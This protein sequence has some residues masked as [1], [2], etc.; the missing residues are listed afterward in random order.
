MSNSD[1]IFAGE[2]EID[3]QVRLRSSSSSKPHTARSRLG[4]SGQ[5]SQA[6]ER[7]D[8]EQPLL[9]A[10][11][12]SRGRAGSDG[13]SEL[14]EWFGTAELKGLPWWKKPSVCKRS[15]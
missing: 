10:G 5:S 11:A 15:G 3:E 1:E 4:K 2:A 14:E 9:G 7:N 12:N 6:L 8:E 13:G